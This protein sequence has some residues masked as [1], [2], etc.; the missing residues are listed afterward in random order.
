MWPPSLG[1]RAV[2]LAG[3]IV[4]ALMSFDRSQ[5]PV[6]TPPGANIVL[7]SSMSSI[8]MFV[9]SPFLAP[10]IGLQAGVPPVPAPP[11][12]VPP[13]VE[14]PAVVLPAP[15]AVL[16]MPAVVFVEVPAVAP[17]RLPLSPLPPHAPTRE[18]TKPEAPNRKIEVALRMP[19]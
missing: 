5:E 12:A 9:P 13:V 17:S 14:A 2:V 16:V 10:G 3:M 4:P 19:R 18:K 6:P 8:T 1:A 11:A 7:A 15:A